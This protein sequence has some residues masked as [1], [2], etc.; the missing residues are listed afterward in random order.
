[1]KPIRDDADLAATLQ[2][3]RPTPGPAFTA[4]LDERAA[5]GFPRRAPEHSSPL[6]RVLASLRPTQHRRLIL[7]AAGVALATVAIA[8]A[9]ILSRGEDSKPGVISSASG[10][11]VGGPGHSRSHLR[12][13]SAPV[14]VEMEAGG[15]GPPA[16]PVSSSGARSNFDASASNSAMKGAGPLPGMLR[17]PA[18]SRGRDIERSAEMVLG[19][20]P[21]DVDDA[22]A[23]VFDAVHSSHGIVL[24]SSMDKGAPGGGAE[25]ELLIPSAKLSDALAAFSDIAEVRSRHEATSDITAPTVTAAENL[26]DSR[27]RSDSLLAQLAD[28]DTESEREA[29]ESELRDE[30]HRSAYLRSQLTNLDRRASLSRVSVRIET[31]GASS[32]GDEGAWGIGDALDDAGHIL[33]I[34]AA[35]TLVGLAVIAP[36]ALIALLTWVAYLAWLRRGRQRALG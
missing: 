28:A 21:A 30:R 4:E 31:D 14:P 1:M 35:V 32:S 16:G 18:L 23:R 33:T 7:P 10:V 26:R 24:R 12:Q 19:T 2:T 13:F 27:A 22:A 11:E 9:V 3:L 8:T 5:A 34:A 20:E 29:A 17:N 6:A 36:I 25:F 15:A